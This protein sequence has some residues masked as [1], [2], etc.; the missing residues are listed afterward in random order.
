MPHLTDEQIAEVKAEQVPAE[1]AVPV[2]FLAGGQALNI[3]TGETTPRGTNVIYQTVYWNFTRETAKKI[4]RWLS[5]RAVF[6]K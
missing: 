4:A 2:R 6:S 1:Q 5:V 3:V